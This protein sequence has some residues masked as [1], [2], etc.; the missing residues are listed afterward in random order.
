MGLAETKEAIQAA[1]AAFPSWSRT[2]PKV[3]L[4]AGFF[5]GTPR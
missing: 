2:T 4:Q 5:L 1:A 3:P